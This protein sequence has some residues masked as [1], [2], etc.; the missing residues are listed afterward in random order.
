[1]LDLIAE[2]EGDASYVTYLPELEAE[3]EY[4]MDGSAVERGPMARR[5]P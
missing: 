4:W 2:R 5:W 1:M 3:Y